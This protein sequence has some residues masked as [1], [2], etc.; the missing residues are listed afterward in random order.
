MKLI[1]IFIFI[2]LVFVVLKFFQYRRRRKVLKKLRA[3]WGELPEDGFNLETARL[4]LKF[5]GANE[6]A[7]CYFVDEATWQDL[8]LDDIFQKVNR[9]TTPTGA[10]YLYFLLHH[11]ALTDSILKKRE[12]IINRLIKDSRFRESLQIALSALSDPNAKYLPYALWRPLPE[13]PVYAPLF[14]VLSL[15][16]VVVLI[17]TVLKILNLGFILGLFVFHLFVRMLEKRRI[18]V[19][20]YSFEYLSV[21]I[22]VAER[23]AALKVKGLADIQRQLGEHLKE[24][25]PIASKIYLLQFKDELGLMEYLKIYFLIDIT[26]FYSALSKI[27]RQLTQL[28][29]LFE[30]VGQVDALLAMAS[31]RTE[32]ADTCKPSFGADSDT[33]SV[34]GIWHPLLASPIPND[35]R[36][37]SKN[38]LVTGSNMAGKTTFLKTLGVNSILSQ[39]LNICFA[40]SFT[41]PFLKVISS[42]ERAENIISGKSYYLAE[43]ESILRIINAADSPG[44]HL[45]IID[46]IFR[47][48]NSVERTA[49][50]IEVLKYLANAKDFVIVA[51]HDMQL[52]ERLENKYLNYHFREEMTAEGLTFDYKIHPGPSTS[53]NAIALLG[54][55]GYPEKIVTAASRHIQE[56]SPLAQS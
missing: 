41:A 30:I 2:A 40:E 56:E 1:Q 48:T 17:L 50:S 9:A 10:Q 42:I 52:T 15:V 34:K 54:F 12:A 19:F 21:L 39:T 49:A 47:G 26:G 22:G 28:Q 11:P 3:E 14:P 44:L 20:L 5:R 38:I 33:I 37:E 13:K 6:A 18:D 43:V 16:A 55:V 8:D 31:F 35:F 46:E 25:R 36:F 23:L 51:T 32:Y 53:R 45:L 4:F 7:D 24:T 27:E 29:A